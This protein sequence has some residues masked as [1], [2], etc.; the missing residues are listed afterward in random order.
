MRQI[1]YKPANGWVGDI[2]PFFK[3]GEYK[4]FY[5]HD[6]RNNQIGRAHV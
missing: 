4:L 5:I 1:F 3:N 2:I 6:F